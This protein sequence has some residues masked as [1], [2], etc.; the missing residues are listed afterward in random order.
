[1]ER[2]T[3]LE[4]VS[5][6]HLVLERTPPTRASHIYTRLRLELI[7][8][9]FDFADTIFPH[10]VWEKS[11]TGLKGFETLQTYLTQI[12]WC[13]LPQPR[14]SLKKKH[15]LMP[16]L[17]EIIFWGSKVEEGAHFQKFYNYSFSIHSL[18]TKKNILK[19]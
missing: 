19:D 11:L 4:Y 3:A 7:K 10:Y 2:K 12:F 18:W 15:R 8:W 5:L 16:M 9:K 14:S 17:S 1:M 13:G 6:R